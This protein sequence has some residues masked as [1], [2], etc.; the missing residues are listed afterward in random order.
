MVGGGPSRGETSPP[1]LVVGGGKAAMKG[2]PAAPQCAGSR[3]GAGGA[4]SPPYLMA[5]G[6]E[7]L[8]ERVVTG[9]GRGPHTSGCAG[10][11]QRTTDPATGRRPVVTNGAH[12]LGLGLALRLK[13][14]GGREQ[15]ERGRRAAP[16]PSLQLHELP[17]CSSGGG[18]GR[19]RVPPMSPREG[20]CKQ[21]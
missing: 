15:D 21:L 6:G 20:Q 13:R 19:V 10:P 4:T 11:D 17:T 7:T 3:T 14:R 5:G 9:G 12:D 1:D 16:P 2:G 18:E 8:I